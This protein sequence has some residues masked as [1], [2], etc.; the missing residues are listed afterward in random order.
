MTERAAQLLVAATVISP[1]ASALVVQLASG[2]RPAHL[3]N[4]GLGLVCGI[5]GIAA[6]V[7]MLAGVEVGS[8]VL[9]GDALTG[10]YV[11]VIS[12]VSL[13]SALLSPS[14][15]RGGSGETFFAARRSVRSYY[16][17]LYAFWGALVAIPLV[18]NLGV[19]WLVVEATTAASA[20]LVAYS[21]KPRA[22]E[23]GWKYLV[24][25]TLGLSLAFLGIVLV[26]VA[27][28]PHAGGLGLLDWSTLPEALGRMSHRAA[29]VAYALVMLGLIAKIGLAPLQNWLPDAHSEAPAPVSAML[30][31]ALLPAVMLLA[32]RMR[33]AAIGV[34]GA[35]A[36]NLPL[37]VFGM[38]SVAVAVPFLWQ[39]IAWKRMLAYSSLEHMGIIAVGITFASP[40]ALVGVVVHVSG[41]A[42]AKALGF[43]A[44]VPLF[45]TQPRAGRHSAVGIA[46][47]SPRT[48]AAM[49]VSVVTLG[50]LPP[51]PLFLSELF[52]VLGG[53]RSGH[54]VAATVLALL[55]ALAYVGLLGSLLDAARADGHGATGV[56]G[57]GVV[58]P[59]GAAAASGSRIAVATLGSVVAL[60]CLAAAAIA[61]PGSEL[62][63]RIGSGA[64]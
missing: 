3:L 25:T 31:A 6:S 39:P 44:S 2:A 9:M 56:G 38:L 63:T 15:L 60:A 13:T 16:L 19:A 35:E 51:S 49:A 18:A 42:V 48:F 43:H 22:L 58:A 40:I 28:A 20:V 53:I 61:L 50:G 64:A 46:S 27:A 37:V 10:V 12:V 4:I 21:G 30:S 7:T 52:I 23:A 29:T 41:H 11:G 45:A 33:D 55:V 14:Y 34:L 8:G 5:I 47:S 32:W 36:A 62:A 17:A 1:L 26:F 59:D 24:L 54:V 57:A